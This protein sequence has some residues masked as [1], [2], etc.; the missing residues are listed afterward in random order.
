M[1]RHTQHLV[2]ALRKLAGPRVDVGRG[3]RSVAPAFAFLAP[4]VPFPT[5]IE[6]NAATPLRNVADSVRH[7]A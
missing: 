3:V 1:A 6:G 2:T 5:G 4:I 7:V